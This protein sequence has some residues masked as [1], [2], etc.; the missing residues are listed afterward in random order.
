M[1]IFCVFSSDLSYLTTFFSQQKLPIYPGSSLSPL[2]HPGYGPQVK[3]KVTLS[4]PM[5]YAVHGILQ[6]RI[7]EWIVSPFSGDLPHPGSQVDSLLAETQGKP[8]N[9]G[10]DSQSFLQQIFPTQESNWGLL[11]CREILHQ[12]SY[13]GSQIKHNSQVLGCAC[14]FF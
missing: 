11:H 8:K 10:V 2:E 3:V 14:I 5:D 4:N 6:A 13:R 9:T 7:L 12:L 1:A